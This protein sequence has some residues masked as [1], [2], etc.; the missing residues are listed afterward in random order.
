MAISKWALSF[1]GKYELEM[2]RVS[3]YERIMIIDYIIKP[4][5]YKIQTKHNYHIAVLSYTVLQDTI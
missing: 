4:P 3:V 1:N 2:H 5:T